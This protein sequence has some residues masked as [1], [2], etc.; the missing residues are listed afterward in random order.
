MTRTLRND[1]LLTLDAGFRSGLIE[2]IGSTALPWPDNSIPAAYVSDHADSQL[3][4]V[5]TTRLALAELLMGF[6]DLV[7][8]LVICLYHWLVKRASTLFLLKPGDRFMF[9]GVTFTPLFV[10]MM[11]GTATSCVSS[12]VYL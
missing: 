8:L 5:P 6:A 3:W 4:S 10:Y 7:W 12:L 1:K 2:L 9:V 11:C